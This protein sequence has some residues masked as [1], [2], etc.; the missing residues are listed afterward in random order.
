M[1][2][3]RLVRRWI[4]IVVI[5]FVAGGLTL[6]FF[7][8]ESIVTVDVGVCTNVALAIGVGVI[9][10]WTRRCHHLALSAIL[11]AITTVLGVDGLIL[12]SPGSTFGWSDLWGF[13]TIAVVV[14]LLG[15]AIL[16]GGGAAVATMAHGLAQKCR[17]SDIIPAT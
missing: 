16:L 13:D 12:V 9:L 5:S 17:Y 14:A 10:G 2:V 15:M 8:S 1:S 4:A 6:A 3:P 7:P 11:G